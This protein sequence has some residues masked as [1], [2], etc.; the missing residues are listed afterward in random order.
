MNQCIRYT[1]VGGES[2]R[3]CENQAAPG[4][5]TCAECYRNL[6]EQRPA[7]RARV[8]NL[9]RCDGRTVRGVRCK[10]RRW[11]GSRFCRRHHPG[12]QCIH[13]EPVKFQKRGSTRRAPKQCLRPTEV[14][15][16]LCPE[17]QAQML[18]DEGVTH[19]RG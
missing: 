16:A 15:K 6:A 2:P 17:H 7:E 8:P 12:L 13:M 10:E 14:G 3:R 1:R 5:N 19:P 4:S 9:E 11:D 18:A